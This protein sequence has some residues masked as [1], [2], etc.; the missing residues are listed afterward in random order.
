MRSKILVAG[1]DS[2]FCRSFFQAVE[3]RGVCVEKI[4]IKTHS[5]GEMELGAFS[6]GAK[7]LVLQLPFLS[8]NKTF[9]CA[10]L[11]NK[12]FPVLPFCIPFVPYARNLESF[13]ALY[14][15]F[16]KIQT[17]DFHMSKTSFPFL[18]D[19]D[20]SDF[21][22]KALQGFSFD[23]KTTFVL[24]PD[25]GSLR[26]ATRLGQVLQLP[27]FIAEKKRMERECLVSLPDIPPS[28]RTCIVRDDILDSGETLEAAITSL[29]RMGIFRIIAVVTHVLS[30]DWDPSLQGID[31]VTLDIFEGPSQSSLFKIPFAD[32]LLS[33]ILDLPRGF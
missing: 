16:R 1:A 6:G 4:P 11:L 20:L 17:F 32:F 14:S 25:K 7:D 15:D 8:P 22:A 10:Q 30:S 26:R 28:F 2:S 5:S 19:E 29:K 12:K 9:L 27:V 18:R 3:A 33:R 21:F 31:L 24:G 13:S 23:E